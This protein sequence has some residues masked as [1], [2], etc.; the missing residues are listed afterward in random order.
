MPGLELSVLRRS[1]FEDRRRVPEPDSGRRSR[2]PARRCFPD[3]SANVLRRR[4]HLKSD[5]VRPDELLLTLGC[6]RWT[7]TASESVSNCSRDWPLDGPLATAHMIGHVAEFGPLALQWLE[8]WARKKHIAASDRVRHEL[9]T[10]T[11]IRD[12]L[13]RPAQFT[14]AGQGRGFVGR[15]QA[16]TKAHS[17]VEAAPSP[18]TR[19]IDGDPPH[20]ERDYFTFHRRSARWCV[21]RDEGTNFVASWVVGITRPSPYTLGAPAS[22]PCTAISQMSCM[23]TTRPWRALS[24]PSCKALVGARSGRGVFCAFPWFLL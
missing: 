7:T 18:L 15:L 8:I 19:T 16:L 2:T 6:W 14:D 12:V 11:S 21:P 3:T 17:V 23:I 10:L 5:N 22:S 20:H 24:L 1:L 9:Q 4:I 13:V